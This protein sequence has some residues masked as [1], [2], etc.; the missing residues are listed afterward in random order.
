MK[1][2]ITDLEAYNNGYLV[3]EWIEFPMS[4]DEVSEAIKNVLFKGQKACNDN[5]LHE[6]VF[7]TDYEADMNIKEYDNIYVLNE[8]AQALENFDEDELLKFKFLASQGYKERDII[9]NGLDTYDVEI[10][11]FRN[12]TSFTD[13]FEL[14][15]MQ[16]I[17]D[18]VYGVIPENLESYID[19]EKIAR[20]LRMDYCEFESRVIARTL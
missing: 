17:D 19:Y 16:F 14:L 3:G 1:I 20:D 2:Y 6:E 5:Y 18:G 9:E 10:Y 4:E 15:A 11:D 13:T 7:I 8:I 12:N